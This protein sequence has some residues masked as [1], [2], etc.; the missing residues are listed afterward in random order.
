ML[1]QLLG[2]VADRCETISTMYSLA[3]PV[4]IDLVTEPAV[5]V[6]VELTSGCVVWCAPVNDTPDNPSLVGCPGDGRYDVV[7]AG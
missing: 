5:P 6:V 7:R 2:A 3:A 4:V 1:V